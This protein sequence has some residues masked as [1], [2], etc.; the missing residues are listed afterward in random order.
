MT[1]APVPPSAPKLMPSP[2]CQLP[3][4]A[5][6]PCRL[7]LLAVAGILGSLSGT[8]QAGP[9]ATVADCLRPPQ[10]VSGAPVLVP[11]GASKPQLLAQALPSSGAVAGRTS[12]RRDSSPQLAQATSPESLPACTYDPPLPPTPTI[13]RGLW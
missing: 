7:G 10:A 12:Q 3:A 4:S 13:I 2:I 1:L 9:T 8:A 11:P 6:L 5:S